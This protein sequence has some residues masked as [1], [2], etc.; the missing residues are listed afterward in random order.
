MVVDGAEG[1]RQTF[2]L[3]EVACSVTT[4]DRWRRCDPRHDRGPALRRHR[5][6]NRQREKNGY[7]FERRPDRW[8]WTVERTKRYVKLERSGRWRLLSHRQR[9][10]RASICGGHLEFDQGCTTCPRRSKHCRLDE[11]ATVTNRQK[12]S[13]R[14]ESTRRSWPTT[15]RSI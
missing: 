8:L 11:R 5:M 9:G 15:V 14:G 1:P 3:D 6:T 12:E 4:G 7:F 10:H 2:Q 13:E